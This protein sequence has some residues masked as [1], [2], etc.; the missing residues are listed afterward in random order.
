MPLAVL[1][2][3]A[4]CLEK[5]PCVRGNP[6][7]SLTNYDTQPNVIPLRCSVG[8]ALQVLP[9]PDADILREW[10]DDQRCY[11]AARIYTAMRD[12]AADPVND[13]P[14]QVSEQ[15]IGRHRRRVCSCL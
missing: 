14:I 15:Q 11:S 2:E 6:T 8:L 13:F 12:Y 1:P 7:V 5:H 3:E 10:L 4:T 9:E